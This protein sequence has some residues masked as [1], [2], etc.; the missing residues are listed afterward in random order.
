MSLRRLTEGNGGWDVMNPKPNNE[1][2]SQINAQRV[3]PL[4]SFEPSPPSKG[5]F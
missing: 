1:C 5:D 3:I 2:L 4:G